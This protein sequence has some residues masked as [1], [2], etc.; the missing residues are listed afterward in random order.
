MLLSGVFDF[1]LFSARAFVLMFACRVGFHILQVVKSIITTAYRL[2]KGC[3]S[4]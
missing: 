1:S 2:T 3:S 4:N